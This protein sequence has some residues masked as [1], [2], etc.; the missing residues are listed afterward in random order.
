MIVEFNHQQ[1]DISRENYGDVIFDYCIVKNHQ[2]GTYMGCVL[3]NIV[4]PIYH[5]MKRKKQQ[6]T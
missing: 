4:P 3:K 6:E 2:Y 5:Q 1:W